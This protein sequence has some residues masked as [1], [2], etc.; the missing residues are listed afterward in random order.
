MLLKSAAPPKA[1]KLPLLC[2]CSGGGAGATGALPGQFCLFAVGVTA[3][4]E[5]GAALHARFAQVVDGVPVE[6]ARYDFNVSH[7]NLVAFGAVRWAPVEIS[8]VPTV[9]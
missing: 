1:S 4:P 9:S 3:T 2:G 6:G 8:T 7:G 5:L